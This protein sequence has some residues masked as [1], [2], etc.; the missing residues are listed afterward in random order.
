MYLGHVIQVVPKIRDGDI[1]MAVDCR[2]QFIEGS[3]GDNQ[4]KSEDEAK[5]KGVDWTK[6]R[7][8]TAKGRI[9]GKPGEIVLVPFQQ[10]EDGRRL[11]GLFKS[12]LTSPSDGP[13]DGRR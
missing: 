1:E 2:Y 3:F 7:S 5:W 8:S 12:T 9:I 13:Q 4:P 10:E 11:Y 6:L